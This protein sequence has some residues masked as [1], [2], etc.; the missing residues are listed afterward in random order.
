[1]ASKRAKDTGGVSDDSMLINSKIY[2]DYAHP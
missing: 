1:M 2:E